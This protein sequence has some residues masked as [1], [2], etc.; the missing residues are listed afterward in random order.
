[1]DKTILI[2][3]F[4]NNKSQLKEHQLIKSL[5]KITFL[6]QNSGIVHHALTKLILDRYE[7]C[8]DKLD[9]FQKIVRDR[10]VKCCKDCNYYYM[11]RHFICEHCHKIDASF[12]SLLCD[13]CFDHRRMCIQCWHR[14]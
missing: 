12:T 13:H 3:L 5:E 1:M 10:S 7:G 9:H 11:S 14:Q 8:H 6:S 4:D 2:I